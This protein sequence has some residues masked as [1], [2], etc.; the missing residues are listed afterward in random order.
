VDTD[1]HLGT[2]DIDA[3]LAAPATEPAPAAK[4]GWGPHPLAGAPR[5]PMWAILET[6]GM[7][8]ASIIACLI[9]AHFV[10]RA[11]GTSLFEGDPKSVGMGWAMAIGSVVQ[12]ASLVA[13]VWYF[14]STKGRDRIQVLLLAPTRKGWRTYASSLAV[15]FGFVAVMSAIIHWIDPNA[16][17]ADLVSFRDMV[18]QPSWWLIVLMVSVG[19]PLAEELL[20][21]GYL[22][23]GL[24]PSR[25]GVIGA[26][27]VTTLG[28]GLLHGYTNWGLFQVCAM[29]ILFSIILVRTGSLR[30]TIFCHAVHNFIQVMLLLFEVGQ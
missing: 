30:V 8:L 19:A 3:A 22:F 4:L 13:L 15:M 24:A 7:L 26:T 18:K 2:I 10:A 23:S 25:L 29:G 9:V 5:S 28:W 27:V 12:Q 14:A 17:S 21:R 11:N 20:F 1:A 6:L 16:V